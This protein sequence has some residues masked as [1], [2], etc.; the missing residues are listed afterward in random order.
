MISEIAHGF[1]E[2]VVGGWNGR[3]AGAGAVVGFDSEAVE[4]GT[5]VLLWRSTSQGSVFARHCALSLRSLC[6]FFMLSFFFCCG[7]AL[8]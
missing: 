2:D 5:D 7:Y 1:V 6:R 3:A 8:T 4:S